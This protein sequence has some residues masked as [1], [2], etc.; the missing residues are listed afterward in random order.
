MHTSCRR[1]VSVNTHFMGKPLFAKVAGRCL[2]TSPKAMQR[3]APFPTVNITNHLPHEA[4]PQDERENDQPHTN[5]A[6]SSSN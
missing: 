4:A 1:R 3:Y 2:E 6:M 5:F